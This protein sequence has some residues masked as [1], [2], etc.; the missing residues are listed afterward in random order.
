MQICRSSTDTNSTSTT[1]WREMKHNRRHTL[2]RTKKRTICWIH[3]LNGRHEYR[4]YHTPILTQ[5]LTVVAFSRTLKCF[6][7][8]PLDYIVL[9]QH[10]LNW[11]I[12][13]GHGWTEQRNAN[14]HGLH[15]HSIRRHIVRYSNSTKKNKR[16]R[17]N[18]AD[19]EK[20]L[21]IFPF[22]CDVLGFGYILFDMACYWLRSQQ[23]TWE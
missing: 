21:Y 19:R 16:E 5:Q 9:V 13:N 2:R 11:L 1:Q 20:S 22:S 6:D 14:T 10:R 3:M 15:S 18:M 7:H 8:R 23:R 4:I 12:L 17:I